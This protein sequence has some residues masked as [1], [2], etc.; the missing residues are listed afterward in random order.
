MAFSS[1]QLT[2][3]GVVH[4]LEGPYN[5][6]EGPYHIRVALVFQYDEADDWTTSYN[7][8]DEAVLAFENLNNA[9][10][11]HNIFFHRSDFGDCSK[12][13]LKHPYS[14]P[15]ED[16]RNENA[17][18][19][20]IFVFSDDGVAQGDNQTLPI[21]FTTLQGKDGS[22][23]VTSTTVLPHEIGHCLGLFHLDGHPLACNEN[24]NPYCDYSAGPAC[25]CCGD[26]VCD[27]PPLSSNVIE[28]SGCT[29]STDP[30]GLSEDIIRNYM[31]YTN[32]RSCRD[33]FSEEQVKRMWAMLFEASGLQDM[34]AQLQ[35]T[36]YSGNLPAGTYGN[37][38]VESGTDLTITT[39]IEMEPASFIKVERNATLTINSTITAACDEMWQGVILKG[40]SGLPQTPANQ[41]KVVVNSNGKI[42]H[43]KV[44]ISAGEPGV[45]PGGGIIEIKWGTIENCE[46]GVRMGDYGFQKNKAKFWHP[47][48][49][50]T[51]DYRGGN[52]A[53][54]MIQTVGIRR[55][56]M[57][58]GK[59]EDSRTS[60]T[61]PAEQAIGVQLIGSSCGFGTG[62]VFENLF[63]GIW[64]DE[65]I[66]LK[67]SFS[68]FNNT[69][70][71]CLTGIRTDGTSSFKITDSE[72][73][74]GKPANCPSSSLEVTGIQMNGL[75]TDFILEN[76]GFTGNPSAQLT[77]RLIGIA[78]FDT[79]EGMDKTIKEN[80]FATLFEGAL[81]VGKNGSD[82]GGLLYLCNTFS[83]AAPTINLFDP[84]SI[85]VVSGSVR[86]DQGELDPD[87][88]VFLPAGNIFSTLAFTFFNE[89]SNPTVNY[90][91]NQN[92]LEESPDFTEPSFGAENLLGFPLNAT[93]CVDDTEPCPNPPCYE[94]IPINQWKS[95]FF[96]KRNDWQGRVNNL[97]YITDSLQSAAELDTIRFL[98]LEMNDL[99]SKLVQQYSLD[100]NGVEVD[101]IVAWLE[102]AETYSTD[103]RLARHYFFTTDFTSFD[104]LWAQIPIDYTLSDDRLNDY[105]E[106]DS[107]YSLV[108]PHLDSGGSVFKMAQA[109]LDSLS[110]WSEWCSQPGYLARSILRYNGTLV[111]V[112]CLNGG[113]T[114]RSAPYGDIVVTNQLPPLEIYPNPA[115]ETITVSLK[116]ESKSSGTVEF[117]NLGGRLVLSKGY[118]KG[119]KEISIESYGIPAGFYFVKIVSSGMV[120]QTGKVIIHH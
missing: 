115:D 88:D 73:T 114:N 18:A 21:N 1:V 12:W 118:A 56:T 77:E 7:L 42:E 44:G 99:S 76:N 50:I 8:Q 47:D 43:A 71:N 23:L 48:F 87:N 63:V 37:I 100:T 54:I 3:Q 35:E 64:A 33:R 109:D 67:G 97:P 75:T 102:L 9:F 16:I 70:T 83:N 98:R 30:T 104:A 108:R 6:Y 96:L 28:A 101:S 20:V 59:F 105:G 107:I 81:A 25:N 90:Y 15:E 13:Y 36:P 38:V 112:D 74:V 34:Q 58:G 110:F 85:H 106:L 5:T 86:T 53:P 72:F 92:V 39:Q 91:Y 119:A 40:A 93:G 62:T 89:L 4:D 2:A 65:A 55:L 14:K 80:S 69:F 27:T 10:N 19:L 26:S 29:T 66:G 117:Y 111:E 95:D 103:M 46:I 84:Y 61:V 82:M 60:C 79:E 22:N 31:A 24:L 116:M 41:G 45:E 94:S 78:T 120:L 11:K 57:V 32:P 113:V 49:Y 52:S 68:V 51:D 17:D